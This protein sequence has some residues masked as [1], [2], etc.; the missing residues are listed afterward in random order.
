MNDG[1]DFNIFELLILFPIV[2]FQYLWSYLK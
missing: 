2:T 1:I